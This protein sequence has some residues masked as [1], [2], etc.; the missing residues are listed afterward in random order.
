MAGF[1]P[2]QLVALQSAAPSD[3]Q[4][5]TGNDINQSI[6][7][8]LTNSGLF[9]PSQL[10]ALSNDGISGMGTWNSA[11]GPSS[12][13]DQQAQTAMGGVNANNASIAGLAPSST[14]PNAQ[15]TAAGYNPLQPA[16]LQ[17]PATLNATTVNPQYLSPQLTNSLGSQQTVGALVGAN[18][19]QFQQ[20]D[21]QMMQMLATAGLAPSSTAGQTAFNNLA[22]QQ[23]AG[24][25]PSIAS[26]IQ[27]SQGNQLNAGQFNATTGN[28]AAQNNA[29]ALNTTANT[30]L[31]NQNNQQLYNA[32]AYNT[33]GTNYFNAETGA[34]NNTQN[35]F[36]ALNNAG[37]AGSQNLATGQ[38]SGG[39]QLAATT[40][41]TFPVQSGSGYSS[42]GA[43]AGSAG[44]YP[45]PSATTNNYYGT[46]TQAQNSGY[47][48]N[49]SGYGSDLSGAYAVQ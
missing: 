34:Y 1:S 38:Q 15:A 37:L 44:Q 27:N 43:A 17:Q 29:N 36:N 18:Q 14:S 26:A 33:A 6:I 48:P 16:Y 8:S 10:A 13:W 4:G 3:P 25:D 19:P 24:M 9:D 22:Q 41:N 5:M 32:N 28:T 39:N 23:L 47:D 2:Q 42:L 11:T 40:A 7:N 21:Q 31:T 20:Q 35:A 30:N 45:Q 46:N 49:S 12:Q